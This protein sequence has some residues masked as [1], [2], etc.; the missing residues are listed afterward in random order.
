MDS[1]RSTE[2]L[3]AACE[4]GIADVERPLLESPPFPNRPRSPESG[5]LVAHLVLLGLSFFGPLAVACPSLVS[6]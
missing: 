5:P 4:E 6:L 2:S 3:P 1:S